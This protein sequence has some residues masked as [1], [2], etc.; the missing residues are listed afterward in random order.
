MPLVLIETVASCRGG[1]I[2]L[3]FS[4]SLRSTATFSNDEGNSVELL[5]ANIFALK[6]GKKKSSRTVIMSCLQN[7]VPELS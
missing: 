4:I 1:F 2:K 5:Q 6:K 7:L 3:K